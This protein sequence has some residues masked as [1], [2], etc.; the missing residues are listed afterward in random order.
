MSILTA[1]RVG[2][3]FGADDIFEDITLEIPHGAKIA[4][5][6][7][8][9]A[10]KTTLLRI[11]MGLEEPS[12]GTVTRMRGL[13]IGY[14]PQ[15]PELVAD[16]PLWDEMLT[17]FSDLRRREVQLE[18]LAHEMAERPGDEALMARYGELQHEFEAAGGYEFENRI[19]QV[20]Q[21]LGFDQNDYQKPLPIFSGGQK[22]RALL[23]RLLLEDPDLL[24]LDEPTN[25]LDIAAVEWLEGFLNG[26]RGAVLLVSHDR[27]F[28]D[29][30]VTAIWELDWGQM[31]TYRGNYSA[32]VHQRAERRALQF[33]EYEAQREMIAR[34]EEYIRRNM[35]GQNTKQAK[36]RLKRLERLKR[37]QLIERPREHRSLHLHLQANVRSGDK[38]LMTKNLLVG[39]SD[40][41]A[42]LFSVPDLTLYRG[43][44]AAVIG[45]NGVGKTTFLKTLLQ[46][47]EPLSGTAKMGASVKIGY[48]AQAHEL[49][50][51][52][53]TIL[54]E[55]LTVRNMP[56]S[57][58]RDYLGSFLF[59]GDDVFRQINTLSGGE[60]GRIALAKLALDGANFLLLDEPTNH[61]DI[62]SQEV[63]QDMLA[64]FNGTILLVS[65]DR[66]LVD[67]LATQ[68]WSIEPG[69]LTVFEGSYQEFVAAREAAREAAR[70]AAMP[71]PKAPEP[72]A[73][74][75]AK[76]PARPGQGNPGN[77]GAQA[78]KLSPRE[79]EKRIAAVEAA[80][81]ALEVRMVEISGELEAA[82]GAGQVDR[83]RELGE[84]YTAT[85]A[86]IDAR[87]EEWETLLAS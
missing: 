82:S 1:S 36:G 2:K 51:P 39:Y 15:R 30:V 87:M 78:V 65:H 46:Q 20:L 45:P 35:A 34:E 70:Q 80:I 5:V 22:T 44:V 17:A 69:K 4:L 79:R 38:V 54:D 59:S 64:R 85:Q 16:H 19:E 7:P 50:N 21:G 48:F 24:V 74:P 26:W 57:N 11:L 8:N 40:A 71:A 56:I 77:P 66:Y 76:T 9:G 68:I 52:D 47:L 6:G 49:L 12:A 41:P 83:V 29:R 18:S 55:L 84:A 31:E 75:P 32:Y 42:P 33:S 73:P 14:L 72:K 61:L 10:G 60:R 28:M 58:A 27:Y 81:H 62:P 13:R 63:L 37:D 3:A 67:A 25:H 23:A 43:E 53:N 86:E